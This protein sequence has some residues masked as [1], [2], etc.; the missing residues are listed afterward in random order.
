MEWIEECFELF[1]R[2]HLRGQYQLLIVDGHASHMST[3]MIKFTRARK[4]ICLCL[5]PHSTNLLQPLDVGVFGPLKQNFKKLLSDKTCFSTYNINKTD[6]ISL[7]QITRRQ[8][9]SSQNVQSA[10]R[11][12]ILIP[13]NLTVVFQKNLIHSKNNSISAI[14]NTGASSNT[15]IQTRFFSGA[16][17]PT[18]ENIDQVTEI[19]EFVSFFQDQ[20][21]DLP[22]LILL[23]KTFKAAIL[24]LTD[25]II[26]NLTNTELLAANTQKKQQVERTRI[27]Y[28]GR[29]ARVLSMKDVEDR[30]QLAEN[31]KKDKEAK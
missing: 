13:Y 25:W 4:I 1:T 17:P 23:Y 20:T 31:K 19:E 21:L 14:D 2:S 5:P 18:P 28:G 27:Q 12:I 8:G 11:A 16:I 29:G 22:K 6:F 26:I 24:A 10:W 7:I 15:P 9:I 3:E 30:K